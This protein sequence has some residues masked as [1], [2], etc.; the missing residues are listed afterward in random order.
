MS[1]LQ[2]IHIA[3]WVE[4]NEDALKGIDFV[5]FMT[6][7]R[8][9][10]LEK[11]WDRKIKLSILA[12]KQEGCP[13]HKWVYAIQARNTLLRG[14]PCHFDED[15]LHETLE[16]NMSENL[17]VRVQRLMVTDDISLQDWIEVVKDEDE[18]VARERVMVK[19]MARELY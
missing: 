13:F 16:N 5:L 4:A 3:D 18:F 12:S 10:T 14:R 9:E 17:E 8:A 2:D 11:D 7:L 1:R 6:K 19:E 15:S